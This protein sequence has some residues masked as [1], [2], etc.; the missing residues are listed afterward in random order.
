MKLSADSVA[1]SVG[2]HVALREVS[3]LASPGEILALAGPSGSGKTTALHV[4]G[5]LLRPS[6][7]TMLVDGDDA[8]GWSSRRRLRFWRDSATFVFQDYGLI[9]EDTVQA[10][11]EIALLGYPRRDRAQRACRALGRV[12]LEGRETER[13]AALSGGEKQRVSLARAIAKESAVV[14][15]DEPTASLDQENRL[16]V[17]ELLRLQSERGA[18]VVVAT[19]D[20]QLIEDA[21]VV[22]DVGQSDVSQNPAKSSASTIR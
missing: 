5:L 2:G 15:A 4:M 20:E 19:H 10:N 8:G 3:I 11:V 13:V 6:T 16:M 9:H 7:G 12:G 18:T 1:M 21:D 17:H 22:I 14:F